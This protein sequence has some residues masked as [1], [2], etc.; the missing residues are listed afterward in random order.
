MSGLQLSLFPI[1]G[2]GMLLPGFDLA[3]DLRTM[4][5]IV[6]ATRRGAYRA[7]RVNLPSWLRDYATVV[8]IAVHEDVNTGRPTYVIGETK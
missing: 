3:V 5:P 1:R 2:F 6:R 7:R 4:L 8:E